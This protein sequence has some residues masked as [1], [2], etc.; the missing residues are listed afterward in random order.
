[1]NVSRATRLS[2]RK[3]QKSSRENL[4]RSGAPLVDRPGLP[5]ALADQSLTQQLGQSTGRPLILLSD[6][7]EIR[8]RAGW[9]GVRLRQSSV[10]SRR[11]SREPPA[12]DRVEIQDDGSGLTVHQ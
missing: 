4:T 8:R 7:W 11:P 5:F 3:V 10:P 9:R 2:N 12:R 1:M 6:R